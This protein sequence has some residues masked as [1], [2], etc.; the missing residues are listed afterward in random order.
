VAAL[1]QHGKPPTVQLVSVCEQGGG[2]G[3]GDGEGGGGESMGG[4]GGRSS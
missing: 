3:G 2:A 4:G 1:S